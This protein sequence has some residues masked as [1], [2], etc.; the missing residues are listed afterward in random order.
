MA[1]FEKLNQYIQGAMDATISIAQ[2]RRDLLEEAANKI[3]QLWKDSN[4]VQAIFI[5]THN[6][7]RSHL[8][9][10]WAQLA[11]WQY[12]IPMKCY[13]G[14]TEATAFYPSAV[15]A[16]AS[17]GCTI[18][19]EGDQNPCYQIQPD[20]KHVIRSFSKKFDDPSNPQRDFIAFM[21]C[22]DADENCPIVPGALHR[23]SLYYDDP[24][25]FDGTDLEQVK[26]SERCFQIASEMYFMMGLV[27]SK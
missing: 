3:A 27:G 25:S 19:R 14:G 11:A 16:L 13:S 21:T 1:Y 10:I 9:Q 22:S 4:E 15:A 24:K 12:G 18:S 6:S 20:E 26:Y 7:R 8:S 2:D 5:C 23:I 17:A